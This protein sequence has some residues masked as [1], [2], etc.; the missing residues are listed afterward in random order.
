MFRSHVASKPT[1]A[2]D[3]FEDLRIHHKVVVHAQLDSF[4][5]ALQ[6][7]GHTPVTE[8]EHL[9]IKSWMNVLSVFR[10][11]CDKRHRLR[12]DCLLTLNQKVLNEITRADDT[13]FLLR[14]PVL[15]YVS[16]SDIDLEAYT[17]QPETHQKLQSTLPT[18]STYLV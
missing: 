10:S 11:H 12:F 6:S 15:L 14:K 3:G 7:S 2:D 18:Y 8:R 16:D 1:E 13:H 17:S 5:R 9:L 4:H